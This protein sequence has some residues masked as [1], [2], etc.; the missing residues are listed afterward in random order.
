ML[1]NRS[2]TFLV[3]LLL[4]AGISSSAQVETLDK[5]MI[6]ALRRAGNEILLANQD[7][8][9]RVMPIQS[10]EGVYQIEF[11]SEFQFDPGLLSTL[12]EAELSRSNLKANYI[13]EVEDC[14][15]KEVVYSYE[16]YV[17]EQQ[18]IVTCSGRMQPEACY[19][20]ILSLN[21]LQDKLQEPRINESKG[22]SLKWW[23]F[24]VLL[25][26]L[27]VVL[28]RRRQKKLS[29]DNA[30]RIGKYRFEPHRGELVFDALR[31]ELTGKESELL[32]LLY[33]H[34]NETVKRETLLQEVW[35]D[36]GDYVG[37]TLDVFIS[38]LRKK[39]EHDPDLKIQNIRGVGYKLVL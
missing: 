2:S 24:L 16:I 30:I 29:D 39:L 9:S 14:H 4:L 36:E 11:E 31:L 13:L 7:S 5:R 27:G 12:I 26:P 28:W 6:A 38:K 19:R 18:D 20:I 8:T 23:Y 25:L 37:R 1:Q 17:L 35:G 33:Q 32:M 21:N 34:K 22:A 15:S 10:E 3:F